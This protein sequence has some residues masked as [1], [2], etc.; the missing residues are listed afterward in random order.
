MMNTPKV[1]IGVPVYGV[2]RYI[3]RCARSLFEQTYTDIEYIFVDDCSPDKSIDILRQVIE[4]YPFREDQIHIV[5]HVRNRGLAAARNTAVEEATGEFI[6][7]VDSDDYVEHNMVESLLNMQQ[8][9]HSD[10]VSCDAIFHFPDYDLKCSQV[11]SLDSKDLTL[12]TLSGRTL[13]SIWGRLIRLSIYKQYDIK[14]LEGYNMGE[15]YQVIPILLY[16]AKKVSVLHIPLYH[17]N[18]TDLNTYTGSF[19]EQKSRQVYKA[20]SLLNSFFRDKGEEYISAIEYAYTLLLIKDI[21]SCSK[22]GNQE[23]YFQELRNKLLSTNKKNWS[24]IDLPNRIILY[25]NNYK[26]AKIYVSIASKLKNLL[27]RYAHYT[28]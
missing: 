2:E 10:I 22:V 11:D 13:V 16:F 20:V 28:A 8:E 19:S 1:T 5:R 6:T 24:D 18:C 12:K 23:K 9:A 14:A 15:D 7:W 26:F 27:K 17:Y 4:E 3:E 21:I 25:I